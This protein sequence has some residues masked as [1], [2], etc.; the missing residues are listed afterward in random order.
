[1]S[2]TA[3]LK[4]QGSNLIFGLLALNAN[5]GTYNQGFGT[6][7]L[8]YQTSGDRNTGFGYQAGRN[9]VTGDYNVFM[10]FS[11]GR[12]ATS[13]VYHNNVGIGYQAL[14]S[15]NTANKN[16]AV[17]AHALYQIDK[18]VSSVAVGE[19]AGMSG[20]ST[21]FGVSNFQKGLVVTAGVSTFSGIGTFGIQIAKLFGCTVIATASPEKLDKCLELGADYAVDHRKDDWHKEV[22]S[23]AKKIPTMI[24]SHIICN[25]ILS[26]SVVDLC[27]KI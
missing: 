12:G 5:T 19:V 7:A 21:F 24:I 9:N 13:G 4:Q 25:K 23:I 14:Y 10:G 11:A 1:M 22:R 20:I 26:F 2:G 15:V 18:G 3:T 16:T 6:E 27:F 8:G 17:G